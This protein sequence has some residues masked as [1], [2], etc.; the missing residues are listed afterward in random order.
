LEFAAG[1]PATVGGSVR[2]NAGAHGGDVGSRLVRIDAAL[3]GA[4]LDVPAAD[5]GFGYR[6][7]ALPSRSIVLA[8]Y[9]ELTNDDPP[10]I[11]RRLEEIRAWRRT[12]QPLRERNCGSVFTNPLGVSAGAAVEAAGGKGLRIGG[13]TV[14]AK[15]ANFITVTPDARAQD[16]HDLIALVRERVVAAGGPL[17]IPEVRLLGSFTKS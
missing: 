9:W 1:I 6:R 10:A 11:E 2:M 8:A 14:S 17:L 3:G 16:V 12:T 4:V 7:S 15:H 13:A 5:L